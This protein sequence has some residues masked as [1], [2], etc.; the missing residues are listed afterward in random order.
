MTS[1]DEEKKV[2]GPAEMEEKIL[3]FWRTNKIFEKSLAK[4]SPKGEFVFYDGPPF[5]TG[6]PHYGHILASA[7]KDLI[8]RYKTMRGFHI[9]RRWGWDCHG[10]PI[11]NIAEKG[12]KISG[13]KQ[14]EEIGVKKFNEYA[15]SRVLDF[16]GEWQK[17]VDRIGRW[18]DFE[19]SYK[20]MSNSY[21]E[22]VW[23]ALKQV[24]DRGLMYEGTRVLPYCPRCETPIANS[25]IAMDNSYREIKDLSVYV[26]FELEEEPGT[27]LLAWTT[28][29]WTLPGNVALAVNKDLIYCQVK[30]QKLK[31]KGETENLEEGEETLI[32]V[33]DRLADVF[34][35]VE[36]K[37]EK[38]FR[39]ADLIGKKYKPLFDYYINDSKIQNSDRPWHVYGADFVTTE[40]GTG[41]VHIAP[42]FGEEDMNLAQKEGLPLI[43]HVDT[44]GRFKPEVKDFAGLLVK[45]KFDS[46]T[47]EKKEGFGS[48]NYHQI[49]DIEIIKYLDKKNLLYKK[50]KITHSYPHCFRCETPLFYYA[51]PAW[52]IKLQDFKQKLIGLNENINWIP[53][54]LKEG[55][56]RNIL[57]GAPD[58]NISRN[59][60][61]ATPLPIWKCEKCNTIKVLGSLEELI[62]TQPASG[63]R[64]FFMRHGEAESNL[65][66]LISIDPNGPNHLTEKG[67]GE[68][69]AVAKELA[70]KKIDFIFASDFVRTRETAEI[71]ASGLGLKGENVV[72]DQR[73]RELNTG[74]FKGKTW[75]EYDSAAG[76][77]GERFN[78]QLENGGE[79]YNSVRQR[80]M[81]FL[82]EI[83]GKYKGKNFLII[84]HGLPLF[85]VSATL[86]YLEVDEMEKNER[87]FA[88]GEWREIPFFPVPHNDN[89]ELDLHR[90]YIDEIVFPCV[91][92]GQA[93]R[94]VE[95]LDCWFESGSM[96]FAAEHY[97][98]DKEKIDPPAQKRFP[99]QFVVEYIAQT[100]TWFNYMLTVSG[101]LFGS[102]PFENV[103]T[104]GTVL[105]EDGQKMSKSKGNFP[106]P[107]LVFNKYGV[108]ALRFYLLSSPLLKSEDLN[109]S[110]KGVAEVYRKNIARLLNVLSF[111]ETYTENLPTGKFDPRALTNVLDRWIAARL[112][113]TILEVGRTLDNYEIDRALRPIEDFIEDLSVW[114]LR[115]SRDRFKSD[116]KND[117]QQAILTIWHVLRETAKLLAPFCPFVAEHVFQHLRN[118]DDAES[119]HLVV[120]PDDEINFVYTETPIGDEMAEVRRIVSLA[121]E[122]RQT[123]G[124]KV[125]QPLQELRVK[126]V[127]LALKPE[128]YS[129]IL[130]ELNVK[131]LIFDAKLSDEV[132]L[133]TE[134]DEGLRLEGDAREFIRNLQ[135]FRK[136]QGLKP[137]DLISLLIEAPEEGREMIRRF[138]KE[139]KKVAGLKCLEYGIVQDGKEL[140]V[141]DYVFK[142]KI[143]DE[144]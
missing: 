92:G 112:G 20:T 138:E 45:P 131:S 28:T 87:V 76:S 57:E 80:I 143:E 109:F 122:F 101:L 140:A 128:Y 39:G 121:L 83:N 70:G 102:A 69:E 21:M 35:N 26:K 97:P 64:Y 137:N 119:V 29:P 126:S 110:E 63:N 43:W 22:S 48:D 74:S 98:F 46:K 103:V 34:R 55:R 6:L 78:G 37:L 23:W 65:S 115:R 90:P 38:E 96:P 120:W 27:Y 95:V 49:T 144:N 130:E 10:L 68:V 107:W 72:Y 13:K 41:I 2:S 15:R 73:L 33:K 139:I 129:L 104:T 132:W 88:L 4:E 111:F 12:L 47:E 40:D 30:S 50:E 5:A 124:I 53:S 94:I 118:D 62:K 56:F 99:A 89:Y 11:E 135:E 106:D 82:Y 32:V 67:R 42:A 9:P 51:I 3:E 113:A 24:Y 125:R 134:I 66:D 84:S 114:Y 105:A 36:Y 93:K 75:T 123:A 60:F 1:F 52:F 133:D 79:N 141:G 142:I 81:E 14:I 108:D 54:H 19:G 25:E 116:D 7:I 100:R 18:V 86:K 85:L 16:I 117:R 17:T 31:V 8:P 77:L 61:W 127:A 58:W 59:R 136:S 44:T 91:C 71:L